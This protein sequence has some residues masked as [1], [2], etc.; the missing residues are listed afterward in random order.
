MQRRFLITL[1]IPFLFSCAASKKN[2]DNDNA[3]HLKG[4]IIGTYC[5]RYTVIEIVKG[6]VGIEYK[7]CKTGKEYK[8]AAIVGSKD[9]FD[10]TPGKEFYFDV[11]P[12]MMFTMEMPACPDGECVPG[13]KVGIKV[14][15]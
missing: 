2:A 8:R 14:I 4:R 6:D 3:G 7:D 13:S 10:K 9:A 1:L 11:D 12:E 15:N 5:S